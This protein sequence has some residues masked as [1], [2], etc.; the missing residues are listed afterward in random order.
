MVGLYHLTGT[1]IIK[2][3]NEVSIPN[4]KNNLFS[5]GFQEPIFTFIPSIGISEII[6]IPNNFSDHWVDNFI[7]S[8]LWGQS[9]YRLK[10]DDNYEKVIFIEK[11][12]IG[13]RI[14]DLK[15]IKGNDMIIMALEQNGKLGIIKKNF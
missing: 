13:N 10:F 1:N 6:K 15:Y 8:S 4:F 11:I 2:K 7:V 5:L 12:F 9:L 3:K 14:R